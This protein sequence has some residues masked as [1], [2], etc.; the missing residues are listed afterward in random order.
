MTIFSI[1]GCF[2][3]NIMASQEIQKK[4]RLLPGAS[5]LIVNAPQE[6]LEM[7]SETDFDIQP[8]KV[9]IGNYDLIQVFGSE[10]GMLEH[11]VDQYS[12][13][14]KYDCLF[15]ICYPKGGGKIKS[16]LNRNVVWDIASSV[17]MKCVTQIA[18]DETWSAIRCRPVE[19][20]G[21]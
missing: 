4:I 17:G 19:M 9:K 16:D 8:D 18:I 1:F 15:W 20:V 10:I 11:L 3:I 14:G 6:Y 7:M 2:K 21:R 12:G 13:S 5:A